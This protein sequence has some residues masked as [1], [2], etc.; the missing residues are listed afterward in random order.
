M[1]VVGNHTELPVTTF[2]GRGVM[3]KLTHTVRTSFLLMVLVFMV[4]DLATLGLS[5]ELP[6]MFIVVEEFVYWFN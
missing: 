3:D 4:R 2:S 5:T 1:V 6:V